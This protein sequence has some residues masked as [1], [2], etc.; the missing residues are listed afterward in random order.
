MRNQIEA[1]ASILA[2]LMQ[3]NTILRWCCAASMCAL[4]INSTSIHSLPV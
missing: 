3:R 1:T 2:A 4:W